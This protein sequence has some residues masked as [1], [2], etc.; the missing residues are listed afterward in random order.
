M[1]KTKFSKKL[2]GIC[3]VLAMLISAMAVTAESA[4][5]ITTTPENGATGIGS[6]TTVTVSTN[7]VEIDFGSLE[8]LS[9]AITVKGGN[10]AVGDIVYND[11]ENPYSYSF[12]LTGMSRQ[13]TYAVTVRVPLMTDDEPVEKTFKFTTVSNYE[14]L[15][16]IEFE[17]YTWDVGPSSGESPET[18]FNKKDVWWMQDVDHTVVG[19]GIITME[20]GKNADNTYKKTGLVTQMCKGLHTKDIKT[21]QL[22]V[23]ASEPTDIKMYYV[24]NVGNSWF[25]EGDACGNRTLLANQTIAADGAWHIISM[26]PTSDV[27]VNN[28]DHVLSHMWFTATGAAGNSWKAPGVFEID[29]IRYMGNGTVKDTGSGVCKYGF[30]APV[31]TQNGNDSTVTLPSFVNYS[32]H[33]VNVGLIAASYSGNKLTN[34]KYASTGVGAGKTSAAIETVLTNVGADETVKTYLWDM[35]TLKPLS[36]SE[37]YDVSLPKSSVEDADDDEEIVVEPEDTDFEGKTKVLILGNSYTHHAPGNIYTNGQYVKWRGNWGMAATSQAND[38]AHLLKSYAKEKNE[39]VAF[40]IKNI[41]SFESNPAGYQNELSA[42]SEA[43]ALDADIIILT[44]GTNMS[45]DLEYVEEAYKALIDYLDADHDAQ[46]ICGM[47]LGTGDTPKLSMFN[48]AS[49][50]NCNWVDLTDK[51]TGEYLAVDKYGENGVGWHYGDAGMKMVADNI[52]NGR[53]YISDYISAN[54]ADTSK[55]TF[56]GLKDLIPEQ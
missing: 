13:T 19:N 14:V 33:L 24:S 54:V 38:Y 26:V 2:I 23:R 48:A 35:N 55:V 22:R 7:D 45:K 41:Y 25:E 9:N 30:E 29:W 51:A 49:E 37:M 36:T 50:K 44:I 47:L 40:M 34:I 53:E 43:A 4:V 28:A 3:T 27:W 12:A 8:T 1:A 21:I 16:S 39:N 17:G 18:G 20:A 42:L 46:I 52:W 31:T 56:K 32:S 6:E 10:A 5:E 15:E 11:L